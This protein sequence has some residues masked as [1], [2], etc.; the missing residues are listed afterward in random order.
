MVQGLADQFG[1]AVRVWSE[2]LDSTMKFLDSYRLEY[3]LV[4]EGS[5]VEGFSSLAVQ[6]IP[7]TLSC[8]VT[9]THTLTPTLTLTLTRTL[10]L[11]LTLTL[12][13]AHSSL[14]NLSMCRIL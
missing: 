12:T 5:T 9:T 1:M 2:Q 11:T 13:Q 8:I 7:L 4:P 14:L 6:D 10:T 3:A